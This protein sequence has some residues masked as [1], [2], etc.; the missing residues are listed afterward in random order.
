DIPDF[1]VTLSGNGTA[2][3]DFIATMY[4]VNYWDENN[5]RIQFYELS[6]HRA[7]ECTLTLAST[8]GSNVTKTY[9]VRVEEQDHTPL[10]NGYTDGTLV[11]NEE[12]FG[13]T[14]GGMNYITPEGE[15]MYQVYERENPGM[16]FGCTSQY[17][18]IWAGKLIAISKQ[19]VDAGDPLPGGGRVVVAD[20]KTLKRIGSIDDLIF[21]DDARSSDGRAVVGATPS[22]AYVSSSNG[23]YI[24]DLDEVKVSGK[25]TDFDESGSAGA[26]LYSGQTGDMVHAGKYVFGIKQNT[27]AFAIDIETDRVVKQ[28]PMTTVQGITQT[29]D[30]NVWIAS[31]ADGCARF[32]CIDPLTLEENEDLSV[33]FP[34]TVAYPTCSW[35]AWRNTPFVGSHS[36]NAIWFSAGGGIAGGSSKDKY[37][38]WEVGTD[39]GD[40]KLVFDMGTANLAGSN[41][42]VKQKTY[43]TLRYDDR[44]GELIVMTTE[45]SASGHYRYNWTHFI[46]P[47]TGEI[48]RT[49]ALRPYYWFQAFAIFPDK[50]DASI[51]VDDITMSVSDDDLTLD[52]T[53]LVTD[54]DNIDANIK[55]SLIDTP[56][57]VNDD[58]TTSAHAAVS[59]EGRKLTVSPVSAGT[60][61]FTLAAES[62]GRTV[63][64]TVAVNVRKT[65]TGIDDIQGEGNSISCDGQRILISGFNG[66]NFSIYDVAGRKVAS[67][68]VDADKYVFDFGSHNGI[69]IVSSDTNISTKVIIRK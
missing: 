45:D 29:A 25:I 11:I 31:V 51:N 15:M 36:R 26:D 1:D 55:L 66:H 52:L 17:A 6:G 34:A 43:G 61:Y 41:A 44:S 58:N 40:V 50:H 3:D 12:W 59:L 2:K 69:Y 38:C 39:P 56:A 60:H 8:D 24:V 30:G 4:K 68:D 27:G 32:T 33:T 46:N 57:A 54:A 62:N 19:A 9:T 63:S 5:T 23:I 20:A 65:A 67:F 18:A 35:G 21:G 64:K 37:Y 22:K 10:E 49:I 13:H 16:S 42:R 7:G 53:E 14:N 48:L 47:E 28:Y